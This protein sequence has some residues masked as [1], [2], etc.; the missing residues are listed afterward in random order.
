VKKVLYVSSIPWQDL[1]QRQHHICNNLARFGKTIYFSCNS[2]KN[3]KKYIGNSFKEPFVKNRNLKV[4]ELFLLPFIRFSAITKINYLIGFI[5]LFFYTFFDR[6]NYIVILSHPTQ[7]IFLNLPVSE[8]YYDYLDDVSKFREFKNKAT[9][10]RR[11]E[12]KI[13][14]KSKGTFISSKLFAENISYLP[15]E[16]IYF[17]PNGVSFEHFKFKNYE[18]PKD[19][20][21]IKEPIIAFYGAINEC[22]DLDLLTYI[23]SREPNINIILIGNVSKNMNVNNLKSFPNVHFLGY[24]FYSELPSY[25]FNIKTWII[26]FDKNHFSKRTNP[27]KVFEYLASGRKIISTPLP[28]LEYLNEFIDFAD[29]KELFLQKIKQSLNEEYNPNIEKLLNLL[30]NNSWEYLTEI[31]HKFIFNPKIKN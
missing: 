27:V 11:D 16:K 31:I 30:K 19:I 28:E 23:A 8:F 7:R 29:T 1:T 5:F 4:L 3:I 22:I 12:K 24:K 21:S 15:K 20:F 25:L 2:I 14:L 9:K 10:L 18:K 6:K 13:N 17:I 26:P